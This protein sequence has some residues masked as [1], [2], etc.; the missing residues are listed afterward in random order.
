M[1]LCSLTRFLELQEYCGRSFFKKLQDQSPIPSMIRSATG[2]CIVCILTSPV[3]TRRAQ[4]VA[5]LLKVDLEVSTLMKK[6]TT[7]L[8]IGATVALL[9]LPV[10]ATTLN[11]DALQDPCSSVEGKNALYQDFLKNRK[12]DQAKAYDAAKKYLACPPAAEVT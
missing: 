11:N 12:D 5:R 6:I 9:A 7:F 4:P 2:L 1:A 10:A 3:R 8:M